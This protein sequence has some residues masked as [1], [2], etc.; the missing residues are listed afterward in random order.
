MDFP[1]QKIVILKIFPANTN[2]P[3]SKPN[4]TL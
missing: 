1:Q 4:N 2:L 3:T